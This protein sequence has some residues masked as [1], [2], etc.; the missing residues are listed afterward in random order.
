MDKETRRKCLLAPAGYHQVSKLMQIQ[1]SFLFSKVS[2]SLDKAGSTTWS[3]QTQCFYV[4]ILT[5]R[6]YHGSLTL[7]LN[8]DVSSKQFLQAP[9]GLC[10]LLTTCRSIYSV[11]VPPPLS[12]HG[13]SMAGT[14][15]SSTL[16][17]I[18]VRKHKEEWK[19]G[20]PGLQYL[21]SYILLPDAFKMRLSSLPGTL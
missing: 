18:A 21:S 3:G 20:K 13:C 5:L 11:K 14:G 17:K 19:A 7:F 12:I 16:A 1:I 6:C 9:A 4:A 15:G 10:P 2:S 8:K